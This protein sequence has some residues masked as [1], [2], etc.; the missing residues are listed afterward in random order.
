[1]P[2]LDSY[3]QTYTLPCPASPLGLAEK[4]SGK[5]S[6]NFDSRNVQCWESQKR[7]SA[8][9]CQFCKHHHHQGIK[10]EIC[11][12]VGKSN[13]YSKMRVRRP[14]SYRI[15]FVDLNSISISQAKAAQLHSFSI[16]VHENQSDGNNDEGLWEICSEIRKNVFCIEFQSPEEEE[17]DELDQT[18]RHLVGFGSLATHSIILF[19]SSHHSLVGDL[20]VLTLRWHLF[21]F[22][23]GDHVARIDRCGVLPSYRSQKLASQTM[24][25]VMK[26]IHY[27]SQLHGI[28]ILL[29]Q[30]LAPQGSP[31]EQCLQR[32]GYSALSQQQD[33]SLDFVMRGGVAH[34]YL[35]Q[36]LT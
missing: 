5:L 31:L 3:N 1:M 35:G 6:G 20:P 33:S 18:S 24:D 7:M 32:H 28:H 11:G 14:P 21:T 26:D 10:C 34:R 27:V 30:I 17:F 29:L 12:H 19:Y 16:E 36:Y 9:L 23:N 13:L 15:L 22:P 2:F 8:P 4:W 25:W